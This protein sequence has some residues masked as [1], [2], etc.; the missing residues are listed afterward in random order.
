MNKNKFVYILTM[1]LI[2][3]FINS[4]NNTSII[5]S[6]S[7]NEESSLT[8]TDNSSYN[9]SSSSL[10]ES[11]SCIE[12]SSSEE[13]VFLGT[14]LANDNEDV[15][16][17]IASKNQDA[18]WGTIL[19]RGV[20]FEPADPSAVDMYS[21]SLNKDYY[22]ICSYIEEK[23]INIDSSALSITYDYEKVTWIRYDDI[24]KVL[25]KYNDLML[26]QVYLIFDMKILLNFQTNQRDY[27]NT[28]K[29]YCSCYIYYPPDENPFFKLKNKIKKFLE[30]EI[31][32]EEGCH[33]IT[34]NYDDDISDMQ[35][36]YSGIDLFL[37]FYN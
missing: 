17:L 3:L 31:L 35:F 30:K 10:I 36:V 23:Y 16:R 33:Y 12:E 25:D 19:K 9:E 32:I 13:E 5:N 1:I 26:V 34:W 18:T 14:I 6:N 2:A 22:I 8:A 15:Q 28:I 4:C 7:T 27:E 21:V 24:T 11:S 20:K 29:L 37:E